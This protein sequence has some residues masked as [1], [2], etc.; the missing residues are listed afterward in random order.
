MVIINGFVK[1]RKIKRC[2]TLFAVPTYLLYLQIVFMIYKIHKSIQ[3]AN[4]LN[5]RY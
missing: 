2:Q 1:I 5:Q 4:K 3:K